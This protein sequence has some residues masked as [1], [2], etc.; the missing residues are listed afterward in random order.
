MSR[1]LHQKFRPVICSTGI[2]I[3]QWQCVFASSM[4]KA[5]STRNGA[6]C[7]ADRLG[8][9]PCFGQLRSPTVWKGTAEGSSNL[10][11]FSIRGTRFFFFLDR[12]SQHTDRARV[13][14]PGKGREQARRA[15]S[16]CRPN[17]P[18]GRTT[19]TKARGSFKKRWGGE[20]FEFDSSRS[21][22][23][24]LHRLV[25]VRMREI[26]QKALHWSRSGT[27]PSSIPVLLPAPEG[28]RGAWMLEGMFPPLQT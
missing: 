24:H 3:T 25:R 10:I 17:L 11:L 5:V 19:P 15:V 20:G 26:I 22:H 8:C 2:L 6:K 4:M 21:T 16:F 13:K 23:P 1:I 28:S 7:A 9:I 14:R 12:L 18:A 27:G